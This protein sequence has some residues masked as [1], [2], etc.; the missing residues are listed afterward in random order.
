M[1]SDN[2]Y[3]ERYIENNAPIPELDETFTNTLLRAK[4]NIYEAVMY[5]PEAGSDTAQDN[6]LINLYIIQLNNFYNIV[7]LS[8]TA[9]DEQELN[10]LRNS[11]QILPKR[12]VLNNEDIHEQVQSIVD[13]VYNY[14]KTN[15]PRDTIPYSY[16]IDSNLHIHKFKMNETFDTE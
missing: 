10:N 2:E 5:T 16:Y 4:N 3:D 8:T 11:I 1:E 15:S 7:R 12:N 9:K 6:N 13:W 14:F